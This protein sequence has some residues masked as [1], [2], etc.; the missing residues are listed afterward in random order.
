MQRAHRGPVKRVPTP[1]P[2]AAYPATLVGTPVGAGK[3][4]DIERPGSGVGFFPPPPPSLVVSGQPP[5]LAVQ[6][7]DVTAGPVNSTLRNEIAGGK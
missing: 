2:G 1:F 3:P 6:A 7:T 5:A 4:Q